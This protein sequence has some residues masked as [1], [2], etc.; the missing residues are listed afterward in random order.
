M[1]RNQALDTSARRRRHGGF[2]LVELMVTVV[3]A[4]LV[5]AST[6]VFF[7]GQQRIYDTQTKL[8]NV[9]QNLW[10]A[11]EVIS[12]HLRSAGAG[13]ATGCNVIRTYY[14]G[15]GV[16]TMTPSGIKNGAAGAPDEIVVTYF[17]NGSTAMQSTPRPARTSA[18]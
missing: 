16:T 14:D 15:V 1:M 7:A 2:T 8:L 11:M 12:R 9:Q 17:V 10:A 18:F 4:G 3:V 6:F 5:A 13:M